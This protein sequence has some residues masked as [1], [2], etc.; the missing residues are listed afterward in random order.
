MYAE[1]GQARLFGIVIRAAAAT[2]QDIANQQAHS[3]CGRSQY[4]RL[5]LAYMLVSVAPIN[6]DVEL[7]SG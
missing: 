7:E 1:Y 4:Q 2:K 3:V 6:I 5:H